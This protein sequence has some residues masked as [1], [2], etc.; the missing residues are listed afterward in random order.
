MWN[1][2]CQRGRSGGGQ[3]N[4][5]KPYKIMPSPFINRPVSWVAPM[6]TCHDQNDRMCWSAGRWGY[7][8]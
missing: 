6:E 3:F 2:K 1:E 8:D 7:A 5:Y 4:F